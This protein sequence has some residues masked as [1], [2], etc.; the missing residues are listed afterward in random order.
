MS[1]MNCAQ[2]FNSYCNYQT[3]PPVHYGGNS[4]YGHCHNGFGNGAGYQGN[5]MNNN[6]GGWRAPWRCNQHHS[7]QRQGYVIDTNRNGRYDKGR[8]GVLAF[9]MNGDGRIDRR[10]VNRTNDMMQAA[11]G[12]FDLNGDGR[13]NRSE[14]FNG[15]RLQNQ[16]R[17]MD[18]N[19][20]G[21]LSAH[22]MHRAGGKVWVD[23]SRGGGV[24]RNELHS[25]FNMPSGNRWGGSVRLDAVNPFQQASHTS[26]NYFGGNAFHHG[27]PSSH[28]QYGMGAPSY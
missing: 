16:Y 11:T 14:Y 18:R 10:D 9:D 13:V 8:D 17:R 23:S 28:Y 12:N 22:E 20:D 3:R 7:Q 2:N 24:G 25:V 21:I 5:L 6:L 15:R 27:G 1:Y 26:N 4:G 19:R